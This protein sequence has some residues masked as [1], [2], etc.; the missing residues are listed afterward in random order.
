MHIDNLDWSALAVRFGGRSAA[1]LRE[2]WYTDCAPSMRE[3]G[4][5]GTGDDT[6]LLRALRASGAT[7]ETEVDWPAAVEGRTGATALRRWKLMLRHVPGAVDKGFEGC[8]DFLVRRFAPA[9]LTEKGEAGGGA[10]GA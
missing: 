7:E 1:S 3:V 5:W 2:K 10:A 8:V 6:R 9:L 4:T